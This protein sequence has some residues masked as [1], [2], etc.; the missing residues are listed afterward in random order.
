MVR[1][2]EWEYHKN[3]HG[4]YFETKCLN[5]RIYEVTDKWKYFVYRLE[6]S[7]NSYS[8]CP[9]A[10][11]IGRSKTESGAKRLAREHY[12]KNR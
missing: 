10:V 1:V 3:E 5:Y 6:S 9:E 4:V 2:L 11:R 7:A 8:K 12:K